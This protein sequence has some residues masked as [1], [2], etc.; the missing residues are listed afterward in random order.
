MDKNLSYKILLF[1]KENYKKDPYFGISPYDIITFLPNYPEETIIDHIVQLSQKKYI[2]CEE[3]S[4]NHP[5]K[6]VGLT[7]KGNRI[8]ES[9]SL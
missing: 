8:V 4:D 2:I 6:I 1:I 9:I 5:Q 7:S 3:W